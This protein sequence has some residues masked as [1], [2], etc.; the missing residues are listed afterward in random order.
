M[1]AETVL[2]GLGYPVALAVIARFVPVVRERRATWL[3]A[4]HAG[5]VAIMAGW[6]IAGRGGAVAVNG[7]WLVVASAWY[8]F[9]GRH[10]GATGA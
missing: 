3:L 10:P 1:A 9:G 7:G 2:F 6:A 4:H 5:V 8:S